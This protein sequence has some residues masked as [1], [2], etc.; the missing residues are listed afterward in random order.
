MTRSQVTSS[1]VLGTQSTGIG[2]QVTGSQVTPSCDSD[3]HGL[4]S[5]SSRIGF[6]I[7]G[8]SSGRH[9]SDEDVEEGCYFQEEK[10]KLA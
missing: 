4:G 5:G 8:T 1:L 7:V 9:L 10:A 6:Q 2:S 3:T